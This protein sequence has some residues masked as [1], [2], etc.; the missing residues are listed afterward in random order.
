MG[1]RKYVPAFSFDRSDKMTGVTTRKIALLHITLI[2]ILGFTIYSNSLMG[3]FIWEDWHLVKNNSYIRGWYNIPNIF[4]EDMG[5]GAGI[6]FNF[7]RPLTMLTYMM[8]YSIWRLNPFGYHLTNTS[9]HI[10]VSLSI[11]WLLML[12]SGNRFL[13]LF[14]SL[15]FLAHPVHSEA[16]SYI[17]G[18][19]NLLVALFMLM[20]FILYIKSLD[21]GNVVSYVLTILIYAMSI[22]SKESALIFPALLL[23]YH[24]VFKKKI[25]PALF[26]SLLSVVFIYIFF[27]IAAL[28]FLFSDVQNYHMLLKRVPGFFVAIAGYLRLLLVPIGLHA[29]YEDKLFSFLDIRALLGLTASILLLIY[30]FKKRKSQK[31]IS[32]SILWFFIALLPVSS[33]YPVNAFFMS[34]H[35]MYLPSI[36]F[37]VI[38]SDKLRSIDKKKSIG[39]IIIVLLIYS[40]LTIKQNNYWNDSVML[41]KRNAEFAP[42]SYKS[43]NNLGAAYYNHKDTEKA[44]ASFKKA[45]E[46]NPS[47]V[48]AYTKLT[49]L[50]AEIGREKEAIALLKNAIATDYGNRAEYYY[51]LGI[52]YRNIKDNEKAIAS[53]QKAIELK[54]NFSKAYANLGIV[55]QD[56]GNSDEAILLYKKALAINSEEEKA[57]NNLALIYT[58]MGRDKEAL[59]LYKRLTE[60]NPRYVDAYVNLGRLYCIFG[61]YK[62]A[63]TALEKALEFNPNLAIAYNN[64]SIAYFYN[65]KYDLA[66][67]YCDK[68]IELGYKVMPQFTNSLKPYRK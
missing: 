17:T 4:T 33:V 38:A 31:L 55:F 64:L 32:F 25:P 56:I 27:R 60:I 12:L 26:L 10:L 35:W 50:Y 45:I 62:K 42:Y 16:V 19:A 13:S 59:A 61:K 28:K 66:I 47:C 1:K 5:A 43:Y 36:G 52:I 49:S 68:A 3:E 34:E 46:L 63:I 67:K 44:I 14:A 2:A 15:L 21:S 22:L 48:L 20:C 51:Y 11:Y 41:L 40:Y 37:F 39:F 53:F 24:Y 29:D 7:Y 30:A 54:R 65:G 8:D 9:L 18:R 6:Q 57:C 23:T 58:D